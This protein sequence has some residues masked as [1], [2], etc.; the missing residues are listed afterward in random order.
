MMNVL[1]E[2]KENALSYFHAQLMRVTHKSE[3]RYKTS[4]CKSQWKQVNCR[5]IL[6]T[7]AKGRS[8]LSLVLPPTNFINIATASYERP[9]LRV[10][11][12]L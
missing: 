3:L 5:W 4:L 9:P 10:R 2:T 11:P 6:T 8:E 1:L 7:S 12:G